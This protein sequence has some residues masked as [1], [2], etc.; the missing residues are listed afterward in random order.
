MFYSTDSD[1]ALSSQSSQ[2]SSQDTS[3]STPKGLSTTTTDDGDVIT[4]EFKDNPKLRKDFQ[5]KLNKMLDAKDAM[6]APPDPTLTVTSSTKSGKKSNLTPLEQQF[7]EIKKQYQIL[8]P[9]AFSLFLYFFLYLF[10]IFFLYV[11]FIF[12]H[13]L[14]PFIF[15][16]SFSLFYF[17]LF[18]LYFPPLCYY[19][20][21]IIIIFLHFRFFVSSYVLGL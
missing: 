2:A 10:F 7:V 8:F 5:K 12:S 19:Y 4:T 17:V 21:I 13:S 9:P 11:F 15:S 18:F 16:N 3:S 14:F 1:D 20:I 6:N